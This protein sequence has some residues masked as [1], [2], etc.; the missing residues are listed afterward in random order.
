MTKEVAQPAGQRLRRRRPR[1][2]PRASGRRAY[3]GL[4]RGRR[5]SPT[6]AGAAWRPRPGP[7]RP[8]RRWAA[9]PA[10]R[11]GVDRRGRPSGTT[12]RRNAGVAEIAAD[13]AAGADG[14]PL[15]VRAV[16]RR[17]RRPAPLGPA[18]ARRRAGRVARHR[19]RAGERHP[20]WTLPAGTAGGEA[21]LPDRS[22]VTIVPAGRRTR[23]RPRRPGPRRRARAWA[24]KLPG[25]PAA[26]QG[27]AG[28][29][30]RW[31][32][33][34]SPTE[35]PP[36]RP[37]ASWPPAG[38]GGGPSRARAARTA[39]PPLVTPRR[40]GGRA[41]M[42]SGM[43]TSEP[44]VRTSCLPPKHPAAA[45][46]AGMSDTPGPVPPDA[47]GHAGRAATNHRSGPPGLGG[48]PAAPG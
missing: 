9:P 7:W 33:T 15:A 10:T 21:R 47:R 34:T 28:W 30:C 20:G 16:N 40:P 18:A 27:Q 17:R 29:Y 26:R 41:T 38:G 43:K 1:V 31:N 11:M 13:L 39:T 37:A 6:P 12:T 3:R 22:V 19:P 45:M 5:S 2:C 14:T 36:G 24:L 35:S 32:S 23:L 4:L 48:G 42:N 46:I 44:E 25:F 8:T